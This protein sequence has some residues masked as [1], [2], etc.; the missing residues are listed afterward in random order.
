[1]VTTLLLLLLLLL[2]KVYHIKNGDNFYEYTENSTMN[3]PQRF[4]LDRT[5]KLNLK[6][7]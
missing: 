5:D 3:E 7:P 1:M 4:R 2:L 6:N